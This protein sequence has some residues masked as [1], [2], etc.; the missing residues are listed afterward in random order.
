MFRRNPLKSQDFFILDPYM[1][2]NAR[3]LINILFHYKLKKVIWFFTIETVK[4]L[5]C[6]NIFLIKEANSE[7][8]FYVI[9]LRLKII[10]TN[11]NNLFCR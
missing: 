7:I 4:L 2:T 6:N 8:N 3:Y 5:F 1:L 9:L 11:D 10:A